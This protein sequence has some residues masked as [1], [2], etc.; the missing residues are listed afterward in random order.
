M[1]Q[2]EEDE[3]KKDYNNC[4]VSENISFANVMFVLCRFGWDLSCLRLNVLKQNVWRMI[5]LIY[6]W[7]LFS[8]EIDFLR[9]CLSFLWL[10]RDPKVVSSDLDI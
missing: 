10:V 1:K 2:K 7:H 8:D 4:I 6:F 9:T 5:P 3:N